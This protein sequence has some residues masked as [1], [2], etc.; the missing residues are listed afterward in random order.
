[1]MFTHWKTHRWFL[2][3]F[4]GLLFLNLTTA[5]PLAQGQE[6]GPI[7]SLVITAQGFE[8]RPVV[9]YAGLT[10]IVSGPDG[11]I[12]QQD[13]PAGA[14]P[15]FTLVDQHGQPYPDGVYTYEL[16]RVAS[17]TQ[18]RTDDAAPGTPAVA[19]SGAA[20]QSGTF[21]IAQGAPVAG[22]TTEPASAQAPQAPQ[23]PNDQVIA[24]DLI[25][26]GSQCLG[27][28]CA[29]GESFGFDTLRL[30]K[31][32]LQIHFDDT[33]ATTGFP[34][35]DWRIVIN[36]SSSG[37]ANYFGI[38]DSTAGRTLFKLMAG[39]PSNAFYM[40]ASG[41][42]GL[43]TAT[44]VLDLH[45]VS[46]NTPAVRLDQDTSS[47]WSAQVWEVAGNETNFFIRD[48]TGGSLLPFRIQ[49]GAPSSALT[50]RSDGNVGLGTW[51]PNYPVELEKTGAN[52]IFAA[53]RTDGATGALTAGAAGV[54]V[55]SLTAHPLALVVND[56]PVMTLN[57]G[58]ELQVHN[59]GITWT[60]SFAASGL[61]IAS[62]NGS[63]NAFVL[64]TSGNLTL[65]G[66]VIESSDVNVKENFAPV[67]VAAVLAR[68]AELP[69]TTWAYQA[70]AA[71]RHM[72][73][74]AQDFYAAFGLGA[75]ARHLAPLDANGVA[76][77]AI[78][79]LAQENQAQETRLAQ[80][81]QEN[82]D[83]EARLAALES[84]VLDLAQE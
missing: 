7:A 26:T 1:M 47:G 61:T 19:T 11:R 57:T 68:V 14:L 10:L 60:L 18:R 63:P 80:L 70:D 42:L 27:F 78:Q 39:A 4:L 8:W 5:T 36:D 50:L 76:L 55:G 79:A 48:V 2:I 46:G 23:A 69:I 32:N 30:K 17:G 15:V 65:A 21:A 64:D 84:L 58:G 12:V 83:L 52:A 20:T 45:I 62:N 73:P 67:D 24:D 3:V 35:N 53:Q 72:G 37:G 22:V 56:A 43:G 44:P 75:D 40:D 33:S 9:E 38:E 49:P 16:R 71:A 59:A 77:A 6:L 29:D 28:D 74:M 25:V 81:E 34:A 41:R 54:Q 13:F 66:A 51:A 31:N 82:A